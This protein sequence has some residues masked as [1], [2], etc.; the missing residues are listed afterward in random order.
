[1]TR[2]EKEI[3]EWFA[4]DKVLTTMKALD[5]TWAHSPHTTVADVRTKGMEC[6]RNAIEES[7]GHCRF[8]YCTAGFHVTVWR[9]E[10]KGKVKAVELN[11]VAAGWIATD[12]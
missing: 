11:F 8:V 2:I 12:E 9:S 5:W 1:M 7:V 6:V 3:E 4:W 10:K